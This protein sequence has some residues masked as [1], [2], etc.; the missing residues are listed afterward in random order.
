[1][2]LTTPSSLGNPICI[3]VNFILNYQGA[4]SSNATAR[5]NGL[6][7]QLSYVEQTQSDLHL[8]HY[9]A[10]LVLKLTAPIQANAVVPSTIK[11]TWNAGNPYSC[12]DIIKEK[13]ETTKA[14]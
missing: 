3:H 12:R 1:M 8:L 7:Q 6:Y 2:L 11:H 9:A 10:M 14:Q 13:R 4:Q 5:G